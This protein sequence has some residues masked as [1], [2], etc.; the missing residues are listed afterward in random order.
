LPA[1][2]STNPRAPR[3]GSTELGE[4]GIG[5]WEWGDRALWGYGSEYGESEVRGA[6]EAAVAAGIRLFDT[7]EIYG[8]G[9][10]ERLLGRFVRDSGA[11]VALATKFFPYPG[12][13]FV[14]G[15]LLSALRSSLDRLGLDHIELYQIHWPLPLANTVWADE[16]ASAVESGLTR[17]VGV[18]NFGAR[19]LSKMHAALLR[20]GVRLSTNQIQ[21]SLLHRDP[22]RD[23]LLA[24]C[25]E[26]GVQVI[27]YSPL[28]QG[29]L[30]GRYSPD[31]PPALRRRVQAGAKLQRA[32]RVLPTLHQIADTHDRTPAQVALNWLI[33]NGTIPIPGAKSGEQA[34]QNAA[35]IGWRLSPDEV[36]QLD[37]VS[38]IP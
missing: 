13:L 19:K 9:E 29:L 18:S 37:H 20:R 15:S 31:H 26:L 23:G 16:L 32:W 21:Y 24:A 38:A 14:R 10:S 2:P 35:A 25:Q 22:E 34:R 11:S 28:A 3:D 4:L 8:R 17:Q 1:R 36:E 27:A 5:T 33:C 6:F 7:A 12:R 30:G